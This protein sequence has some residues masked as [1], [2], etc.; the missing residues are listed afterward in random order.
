MDVRRRESEERKEKH[1]FEF[2]TKKAAH[3]AAK[4]SKKLDGGYEG[5]DGDDGDGGDEGMDGDGGYEGMD[6]GWRV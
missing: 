2:G 4:V 3:C 6:G 5:M 1:L